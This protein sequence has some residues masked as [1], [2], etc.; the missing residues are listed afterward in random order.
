[1][2]NENDIKSLFSKIDLNQEEQVYLN[3][4]ATRLTYTTNLVQEFCNHHPVRKVLDIGPH[5]LTRCVKEFI[6]PEISVST[7]GYEYP[8][9]VPANIIDEHVHYDLS[10]CIKK[11]PAISKN[12]PFDLILFCETIEHL[13]ISPSLVMD[14]LRKLL[15]TKNGGLLIQTPN[16]VTLKKRIKMLFGENPFELLR[17]DFEYKGH[18]REYTMD[19]MEN[20]GNTLGFS[21]WRKAYCNYWPQLRSANKIMRIMEALIPSFRQGITISFKS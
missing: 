16:A 5:F 3:S 6:R 9:L 7:L 20:Y 13:Y 14:F 19:E 11:K 15:I 8:K 2:I 4:Q 1:M 18:I 17:E 12:T 21:I 10:D